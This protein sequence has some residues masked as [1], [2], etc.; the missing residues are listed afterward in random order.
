MLA[1]GKK[2]L[3]LRFFL[4]PL[5]IL[6]GNNR[7]AGMAFTRPKAF[8]NQEQ[9]TITADAVVKS[10]G[11]QTAPIEGVPF[12]KVKYVIKN[13]RGRVVG[14]DGEP[15]RGMYVAGWAK[16]GPVGIIDATLRDAKETYQEI[17]QDIQSNS[18]V[19]KP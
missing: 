12:D 8:S 7:L 3:I 6:V 19:P 17:L 1:D 9:V 15:V 18:L 2:K 10:I 4:Q 11:Y 5:E 14:E 13:V 16:R